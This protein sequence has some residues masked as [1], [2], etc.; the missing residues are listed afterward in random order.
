M[1][2]SFIIFIFPH[3][4]LPVLNYN[5]GKLY[6]QNYITYKLLKLTTMKF[7]SNDSAQLEI[8]DGFINYLILAA[9]AMVLILAFG[10][11][12]DVVSDLFNGKYDSD[13]ASN[14]FYTAGL[15][16]NITSAISGWYILV[17]LLATMALAF[18]I[19]VTIRK[20]GQSRERY[21]DF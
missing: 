19:I 10:P 16:S 2:K 1:W 12:L 5:F 7:K 11:L 17:S 9:L 18:I 20:Q 6:M 4:L 13:F 3:V 8:L 14:P 15:V 21:D